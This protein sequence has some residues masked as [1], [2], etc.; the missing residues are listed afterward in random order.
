MPTVKRVQKQ[1]A[2]VERFEVRFLYQ[3]PGPTAG[4]DVR[5]DRSGIPS[6]TYERAAADDRSVAAWIEGRFKVAFPGF[7]AEVLDGAGRVVS[8]RTKLATVRSTY[9]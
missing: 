7:D 1:I 6:Y 5:D 3:G 8:R 4:R 9:R 2:R